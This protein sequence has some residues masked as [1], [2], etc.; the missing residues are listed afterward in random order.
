M[1]QMQDLNGPDEIRFILSTQFH[2]YIVYLN[3]RNTHL[4]DRLRGDFS[5]RENRA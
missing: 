4:A 2:F 3:S 5:D 1:A